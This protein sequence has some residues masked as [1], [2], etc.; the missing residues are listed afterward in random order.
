MTKKQSLK[1][2]YDSSLRRQQQEMTTEAIMAAVEGLILQGSI[3]NFTIQ[4]VAKSAGVSYASVYRHFPSREAL[5]EGYRDWGMKQISSA[6]PPYVDKLEDLP[7]W[8]EQTIPYFLEY[9]PKV[10][11]LLAAL[12]ALQINEVHPSSRYR[13]EWITRLVKDAVPDVPE[14]I[15]SASCSIIRLLVSITSWVEFY[16]RYGLDESE[17]I[18]TVSEGIRAQIVYLKSAARKK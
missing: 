2:T 5:I 11:A 10:K 16:I 17:L 14:Q 8:V 9:L 7:A 18:L 13:D 15:R 6:A 4:K 1:R 3:H 12:S